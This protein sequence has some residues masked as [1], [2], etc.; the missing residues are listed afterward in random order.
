MNSPY[1]YFANLIEQLP[2]I[3]ADSIVSRT[4]IS[5]DDIKVILFGFAAGQ[6]LSEHTAARPAVLHFLEGEAS[7][8]L[9]KDTFEAGPGTWSHMAPNLPHSIVAKTQVAMLLLML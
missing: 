9:G 8:T 1:Q 2:E 4:I 6:E 5:D 3:P 7:L